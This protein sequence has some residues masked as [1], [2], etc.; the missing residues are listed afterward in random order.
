MTTPYQELF[1]AFRDAR[2]ALNALNDRA[3]TSEVALSRDPEYR[4]L[5]RCG[6]VIARVGGGPAITAA[7]D[8]LSDDESCSAAL[9][10]YWAGM[11]KWPAVSE[12]LAPIAH[13]V[14]HVPEKR[15]RII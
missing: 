8:A 6:M 4:R 7:I 5:H 10:R 13:P 12:T 11:E 3:D 15:G 14:A 2:S 1:S 9:R